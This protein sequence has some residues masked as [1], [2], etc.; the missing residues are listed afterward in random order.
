MLVAGVQVRAGVVVDVVGQVVLCVATITYGWAI[1]DFASP[2]APLAA[3][4]TNA[5]LTTSTTAT[6]VL[7]TAS[8]ASN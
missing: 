8:L 2:I 4:A 5:S 7:Q 6:A 3:V 1:F